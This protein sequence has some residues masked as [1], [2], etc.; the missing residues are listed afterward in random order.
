MDVRI[1]KLIYKFTWLHK[2]CIKFVQYQNDIFYEK[3]KTTGQCVTM[4][5]LKALPTKDRCFIV[6]NGPSLNTKDLELIKGEDCFAANLIFKIFNQTSWRPKYYFIQDRYARIGDFLE[7][8]ALEHL[9]VGAYF[10][11]TRGVKNARALCYN[12]KRLEINDAMQFSA[13]PDQ[14]VYDACTVT[15]VMLQ[16]AIAMGYKRIY[17]LGIDHNYPITIDENDN[18]VVSQSE[19]AH[20]FKDDNPNEV[21][22]NVVMMEKGYKKAKEFAAGQGVEIL[23]ATR[24]GKLEVF[25]RIRLED[26][27]ECDRK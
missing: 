10:W 13:N 16:L 26:V 8:N 22:A 17:L 25:N 7:N 6:G 11:R 4:A 9:F 20:F 2:L 3:L 21:I 18:I 5:K 19:A 12:H 1:R 14:L 23:N 27:Y 15:Y 24:G